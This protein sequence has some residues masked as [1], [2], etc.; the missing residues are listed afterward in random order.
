MKPKKPLPAKGQGTLFSFFSKMEP[1]STSKD[2][3][4]CAKP[5]Q[6]VSKAPTPRKTHADLGQSSKDNEKLVGKRIKVFWRDDNNWYFGKVVDFERE[7]GK[8]VVHY[9]DGDREKLVLA[10]EKVGSLPRVS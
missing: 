10:N 3:L 9:D 8:H 7:D 5:N 2:T 1:P 4:P 6:N